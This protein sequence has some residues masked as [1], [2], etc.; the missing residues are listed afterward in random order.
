MYIY[1]YI[2]TY[3]HTYI[4]CAHD[5]CMRLVASSQ[6]VGPTKFF[7]VSYTSSECTYIYVYIYIYI[8][9]HTY[10]Y[11]YIYI[12]HMMFACDSLLHQK[13]LG[14]PNFSQLYIC[15]I[16][17]YVCVHVC[18]VCP[19]GV[20]LH[21]KE[22]ERPRFSVFCVFVFVFMVGVHAYNI[23]MGLVATEIHTHTY[24]HTYIGMRNGARST[25]Y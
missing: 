15:F 20:L 22:L 13:E 24:M 16:R 10:I 9:I 1:I 11:I 21:Q 6:E 25:C 5:V 2:H 23:S 14:R 17:L 18:M 3:I 7:Q 12:V 19:W 4:Y 8:H